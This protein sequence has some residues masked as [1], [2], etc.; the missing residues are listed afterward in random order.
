MAVHV[1]GRSGVK[2]GPHEVV[3]LEGEISG[4]EARQLGE[5]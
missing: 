4:G 3:E 2:H 5:R 1:A